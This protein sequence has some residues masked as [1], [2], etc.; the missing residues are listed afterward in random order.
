[1]EILILARLVQGAFGA[2]L[3]PTSL[4]LINANFE[5]AERG[6]AFGIW[7]AATSALT[8]WARRSAAS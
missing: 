4:A 2:L 8:S 3:V 5:G 7:A 1:M 6:R